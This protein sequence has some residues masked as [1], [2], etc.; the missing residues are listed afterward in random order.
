MSLRDKEERVWMCVYKGLH[1]QT[2]PICSPWSVDLRT[3]FWVDDT[4]R[5]TIW[6]GEGPLLLVRSLPGRGF[7]NKLT[8]SSSCESEIANKKFHHHLAA[9]VGTEVCVCLC[10]CVP[11]NSYSQAAGRLPWFHCIFVWWEIPLFPLDW[12]PSEALCLN[13][14]HTHNVIAIPLYNTSKSWNVFLTSKLFHMCENHTHLFSWGLC[15]QVGAECKALALHLHDL[16]SSSD[17]SWSAAE[18]TADTQTEN[19]EGSH[20]RIFKCF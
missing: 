13:G 2:L 8:P 18:P 9:S 15:S 3:G 1:S 17:P 12:N 6:G 11:L 19:G 4:L 10:M 20:N 16:H 7:S 5:C 14:Q